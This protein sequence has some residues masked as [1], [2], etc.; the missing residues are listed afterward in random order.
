M[1]VATPYA[2][3]TGCDSCNLVGLVIR[4]KGDEHLLSLLSE[5]QKIKARPQFVIFSYKASF[6]PFIFRVSPCMFKGELCR[7]I[8]KH[9]KISGA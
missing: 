8:G 7:L 2:S 5:L 6:K 3:T 9:R 4:L 1:W